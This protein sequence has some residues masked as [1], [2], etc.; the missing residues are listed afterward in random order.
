MSKAS[1]QSIQELLSL[2]TSLAE[3]GKKQEA[4]EMFMKVLDSEP[5][6]YH[7]KQGLESLIT[8]KI[9]QWHFDMLADTERNNAFEKAIYKAVNEKSIVLDIG[10]GSGLLAMMA[11]RQGAKSVV[12]CEVNP[13]IAKVADRVVR[14]NGYQNQIQVHAKHSDSLMKGVDFQEKFD[15]IVSEILDTGGLGEGVLPSLR[16]A[17][18]HFAKPSATVIP[19]G[20]ALKAKL[21]E[22]PRLHKVNPVNDISG[23]DLSVFNEFNVSDSYNLVNLNQE[24]HRGLSDVFPLRAYD[25]YNI[26]DEVT[27][28]EP[29][30]EPYTI[31]CTADGL[32]QGVAFWFDLH[33]NKEDTLSSGP[34]GE[35]VHWQQAVYYFEK[36]PVVKKGEKVTI[37]ALYSDSLIR[38]RLT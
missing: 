30:E 25:F 21:I 13:D 33:M 27:F 12:A 11:A 8:M 10:T 29:E 35:L 18:K 1:S 16:Y 7:A 31:T 9:P 38:F 15:V 36:P 5:D 22:I 3:R 34:D 20:I 2:G 6:N 28:E 17:L 23:F 19:A 26:P 4:E 14:A 24:E 37:K 32:L